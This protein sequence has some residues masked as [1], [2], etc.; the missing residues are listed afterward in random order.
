[1]SENESVFS[2]FKPLLIA[3]YGLPRSGKSTLARNLAKKLGAPIVAR[4]A[5]QMALHGVRY[6]DDAVPMTRTLSLYMIKSLFEAGHEV[7][8]VDETHW[9]KAARDFIK[10]DRWETRFYEVPTDVTVCLERAYTTAQLDLL[11]VIH[12]MRF[13]HEPLTPSELRYTP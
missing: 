10:D 7:V 5:I 13:R 3:M 9:S 4:D 2:T 12:E 8:V 1:M 11:P 6:L